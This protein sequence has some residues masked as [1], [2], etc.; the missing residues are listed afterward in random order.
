MRRTIFI[1]TLLFVLLL[2]VGSVQA[3]GGGVGWVR[4]G[5]ASIDSEEVNILVNGD[6][7]IE[8]M[9]FGQI[10]LYSPFEEGSIDLEFEVGNSDYDEGS[11]D[12]S[13][14]V[15]EGKSYSIF[16]VGSIDDGT[17]TSSLIE[18]SDY[19]GDDS[20][21]EGYSQLIILNAMDEEGFDVVNAD[22]R[23]AVW[24]EMREIAYVGW[25]FVNGTF[26]LNITDP[27][28][29]DEVLLEDFTEDLEFPAGEGFRYTFVVTGTRRRPEVQMFI[30]GYRT[31]N[32]V[33]QFDR[34]FGLLAEAVEAIEFDDELNTEGNYTLFAPTDDAF[35]NFLE[36]NDLSEGELLDDT[37]T[38]VD[39]LS[40]HVL[41][42]YGTMA[43]LADEGSAETSLDGEE[44]AF[45]LDR[46]GWLVVNDVSV[47]RWIPA[48][49]G[50]I[51]VIDEV[52]EP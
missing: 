2:A 48:L 7:W 25:I 11:A 4:F 45:D 43:E 18:E 34:D 20:D 15:E 36:D 21:W 27:G 42:R 31:I 35:D 19:F 33:L 28:D 8:N 50:V 13:F 37:E 17:F 39:L 24:F 6:D 26:N 47:T 46:S 22:D 3:Q 23:D 5:H 12:F 44:L 14:E 9:E 30:S 32:E 40:Y 29:E 52:L 51:Y 16:V 1:V 49:N 41:L 10:F 38:L